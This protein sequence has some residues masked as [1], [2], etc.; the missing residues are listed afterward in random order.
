[1]NCC[2]E[3]GDCR[4]GRDCPARQACELPELPAKPRYTQAPAK[5][6]V[7]ARA[8][9]LLKR[10]PTWLQDLIGV[11]VMVLVIVWLLGYYG[12]SLDRHASEWTESQALI[13]AQRAAVGAF[14]RDMAAAKLCRETHGESLVRWTAAGELVCVP[15]H[16]KQAQRLASNP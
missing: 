13:D 5:R 3:Y 8:T 4:Q 1:M 14:K 12:P 15:R 10:I 9:A 11:T 6:T 16:S 2:N 7:T